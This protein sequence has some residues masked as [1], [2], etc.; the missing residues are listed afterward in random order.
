MTDSPL[1][2]AP[3]MAFVATTDPAR[4]R[5][6]YEG[7]LGLRLTSDELPFALVFDAHGTMLR[8]TA[9]RELAPAQYTVLGWRVADIA[10]AAGQLAASGVAFERYPGMNQ[11]EQGIW[12]SPSGARVAWF[13]DPDGNTLS[14]TQF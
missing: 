12:K 13:K 6:F 14:L 3:V 8:V 11:D 2:S 4:T 10:A 7:V 5:S 1:A 9:V